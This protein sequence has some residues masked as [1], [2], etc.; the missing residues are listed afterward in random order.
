MERMPTFYEKPSHDLSLKIL[1]DKSRRQ[2]H[3]ATNVNRHIK[4]F[5]ETDA[6]HM[7]MIDADCEVPPH[8]L[9]ELLKLDVDIASGVTFPHKDVRLTTSGRWCPPA[10]PKSRKSKPYF[11]WFTPPEIFGKVIQ[12]PLGVATGAFCL[13]CRRRVFERFHKSF[14]P[15]RFRWNEPQ[16]YSI[17]LQFWKDAQMFGFNAAIHGGVV[18]GHLPEFPL[19][20][21]ELIDWI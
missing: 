13:L 9:C 11:K 5:L 1:K 16:E 7:W 4:K 10:R 20:E 6:T 14:S 18:C 17:D 12:N 15:L 19:K 8:A 3:S 2:K 21:L